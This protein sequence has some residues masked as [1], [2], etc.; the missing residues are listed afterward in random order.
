[1]STNRMDV[2]RSPRAW[3]LA[4]PSA[5]SQSHSLLPALSCLRQSSLTTAISAPAAPLARH[6]SPQTQTR[7]TDFEAVNYA[8]ASYA[9]EWSD[10]DEPVP[11]LADAFCANHERWNVLTH[12]FSAFLVVVYIFLRSI[13]RR[14]IVDSPLRAFDAAWSLHIVA[15]CVAALLLI[16]SAVYHAIPV[17][18]WVIS[19]LFRSLDVGLIVFACGFS[20]FSDVFTSLVAMWSK[21]SLVDGRTNFCEPSLWLFVMTSWRSIFDSAFATTTA[22]FFVFVMLNGIDKSS[23]VTMTGWRHGE[24]RDTRRLSLNSGIYDASHVGCVLTLVILWVITAPIEWNFYPYALGPLTVSFKI[25]CTLLVVLSGAVDRYELVDRCVG[26]YGSRAC[27]AHVPYAHTVWHMV[28]FVVICINIALRDL[29]LSNLVEWYN[30][31]SLHQ[32]VAC[33]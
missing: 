28:G 24:H 13:W 17:N 15:S 6:H 4:P 11:T 27:S 25:L 19:R 14:P 3:A 1:M 8:A 10:E 18:Q 5:R 26:R 29:V 31:T 23:L 30:E 33:P 9:L 2:L 12:G 32:P 21:L 20:T 7:T 16:A 22:L